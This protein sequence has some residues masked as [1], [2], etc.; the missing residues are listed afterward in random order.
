MRVYDTDPGL[1]N[2]YILVSKL[3]RI[4]E[5][6]IDLFPARKKSILCVTNTRIDPSS[7]AAGVLCGGYSAR[8]CRSPQPGWAIFGICIVSTACLSDSTEDDE[9]CDIQDGGMFLGACIRA[10]F[11]CSWACSVEV[12][13]KV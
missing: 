13:V 7:V 8:P 12:V 10:A 9:N 2:H 5:N 6:D 4:S 3:R 1:D 11:V